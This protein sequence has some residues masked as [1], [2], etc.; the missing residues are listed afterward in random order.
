MIPILK[1]PVDSKIQFLQLPRNEQFSK[2]R[3]QGSFTTRPDL[4]LS[5]LAEVPKQFCQR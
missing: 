5:K 2:T 1:S 4:A 3:E